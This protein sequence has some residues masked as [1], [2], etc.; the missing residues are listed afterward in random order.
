MKYYSDS[1]EN[2]YKIASDI[3]D[4]YKGTKILL[5]NGELGSGKTTFVKGFL[6]G[7]GCNEIV[8]SPTFTIVQEY[9][10]REKIY[11]IDLYRLSDLHEAI[12][13]GID[14]YLN[15]GSYVFIEWPNDIEKIIYRD[16]L[17]INFKLENINS[18]II[19]VRHISLKNNKL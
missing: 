18:R 1:V 14:D 16:Y 4:L 3:L 15:S 12:D 10:C 9:D 6:K 13:I 19:E 8:T 17:I 11:H 2:T 5:L 7:L